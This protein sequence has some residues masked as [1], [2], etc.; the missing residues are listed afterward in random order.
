MYVLTISDINGCELSDS[1]EII[2]NPLP[3]VDLGTDTVFCEG[4]SIVLDAG[5]G[6]SYLWMSGET[7]QT[8]TVTT[9]GIYIVTVTDGNSC[10]NS[11]TISVI[12]NPNPVVD[13]GPDYSINYATNTT[14]NSTITAGSGSYNYSW[15]NPGML[16][17]T[18]VA[19]AVTIDLIASQL[20][21]LTVTDA[22]TGCV[23]NDDI[24]INISGGPLSIIDLTPPTSICIGDSIQK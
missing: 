12:V 9:T 11:D 21:N 7:T 19:N 6:Y 17:N 20:F 22:I 5:A 13:L 24:I 14:I 23:G 18:T 3:I 4:G 2:G 16:L 1:L 8:I 10:D 15:D